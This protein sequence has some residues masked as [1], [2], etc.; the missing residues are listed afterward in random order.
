MST[1]YG[2][3]Q[4][5]A[6]GVKRIDTHPEREIRWSTLIISVSI[7][8]CLVL[9]ISPVVI[10]IS[11]LQES[12]ESRSKIVIVIP[13]VT[14]LTAWNRRRWPDAVFLL[15]HTTFDVAFVGLFLYSPLH[16]FTETIDNFSI[17]NYHQCLSYIFSLD[18]NA[19]VN[20]HRGVYYMYI[21]NSKIYWLYGK[22]LT[23]DVIDPIHRTNYFLWSQ[24]R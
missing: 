7:S 3:S 15:D 23:S 19:Y 8:W 9:V 18:L 10:Y 14:H 1:D 24:S 21:V 2:H 6:Q 16:I 22:W 4:H 12:I 13:G 17:W 11:P 5:G 20:E